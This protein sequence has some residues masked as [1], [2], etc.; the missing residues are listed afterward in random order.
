MSYFYMDFNEA[1]QLD[2]LW[3]SNMMLDFFLR[4]LSI[5][6][7]VVTTYG[8]YMKNL[9]GMKKKLISFHEYAINT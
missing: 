3:T 8:A 9:Q 4:Y 5:R 6:T 1:I 2:T 7:Y